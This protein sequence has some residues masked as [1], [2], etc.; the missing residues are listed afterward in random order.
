MRN[1]TGFIPGVPKSENIV[2]T[3]KNQ[4]KHVRIWAC[5]VDNSEQCGECAKCVRTQLNI[6]CTGENPKDWGFARFDEKSSRN[7]C[8][9]TVGLKIVL[10]MYGVLLTP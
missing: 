1:K 9:L 6:L 3:F 4:G 10:M 5:F 2:S 7:W 8:V